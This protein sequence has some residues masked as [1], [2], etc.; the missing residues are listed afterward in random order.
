VIAKTNDRR[1]V[2]AV[3]VAAVVAW[4]AEVATRRFL[5][6]RLGGALS[7]AR[8]LLMTLP[9]TGGLV[10]MLVLVTRCLVVA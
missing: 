1:T 8:T 4:P 5:A 7:L 10:S 9:F 6:W 2:I 3:M